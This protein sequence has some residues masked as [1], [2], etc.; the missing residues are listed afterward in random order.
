MMAGMIAS[1]AIQMQISPNVWVM[2]NT[3]Q[4]LRTILLL[5]I[6]LPQ[7]VRQTIISSSMLSGLDLGLSGKI[8]P[9]AGDE[10]SI[11]RTTL[12]YVLSILI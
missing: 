1:G 3:L 8:M 5:K 11:M 9:Q 10:T 7:I 12:K 6:N 4:I 2:I